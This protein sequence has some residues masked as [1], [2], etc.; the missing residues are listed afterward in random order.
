MA[1][2]NRK[3]REAK[4]GMSG[5]PSS[6]PMTASKI[7]GMDPSQAGEMLREALR[8]KKLADDNTRK[9]VE[10]VNEIRAAH[11]ESVGKIKRSM[12]QMQTRLKEAEN[13]LKHF[14]REN[15][16][17]REERDKLN[18]ELD[19]I[20][21]E[22]QD[23]VRHLNDELT[24]LQA[25]LSELWA[26][27]ERAG[28]L[29]DAE[30]VGA[31]L[32][33]DLDNV[34]AQLQ[35]ARSLEEGNQPSV[36]FAPEEPEP[37]P[38]RLFIDPEARRRTIKRVLMVLVLAGLVAGGWVMRDSPLIGVVLEA[39]QPFLKTMKEIFGNTV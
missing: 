16:S 21:G 37:E 35:A 20:H 2:N 13:K 18:R 15:L 7:E 24:E 27:K 9:A 39:L 3:N 25:Q 22:Q 17:L 19:G 14:E 31:A 28:D 10:Q 6:D 29:V 12:E 5:N 38:E 32:K 34:I 4:P 33:A 26:E 23:Q 36:N 30:E 1:D 11:V 8:Q